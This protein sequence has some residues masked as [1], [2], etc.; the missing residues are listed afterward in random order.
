MYWQV[1]CIDVSVTHC[2]HLITNNW[3]TYWDFPNFIQS[4]CST[5]YKPT[6]TVTLPQP[7]NFLYPYCLR[8]L[9]CSDQMLLV[10]C[11]FGH[12][13]F[14]LNVKVWKSC[15]LIILNYININLNFTCN[16]SILLYWCG[17]RI[18]QKG[19][20]SMPDTGFRIFRRAWLRRPLV[21][22]GF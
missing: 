12:N 15:A 4:I 17:S 9:P 21:V 10:W 16:S 1:L 19:M 7:S 18:L 14:F 11:L 3:L 13:N 20:F 2:M 22:L 8:I 6:H 5:N